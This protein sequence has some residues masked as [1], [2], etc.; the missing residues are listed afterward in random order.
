LTSPQFLAGFVAGNIRELLIKLGLE[1]KEFEGGMKKAQTAIEGLSRTASK[2]SSV[3]TGVFQGIG[4]GIAKGIGNLPASLAALADQGRN[5]NELA[6]SFK[7]L[8]NSSA[9]LD[10]LRSA[11]QGLVSDVELFKSANMAESL[12]ITQQAFGQLAESADA[13]G[14]AVGV[15]TV[16]AL[17]LLTT[18]LGTGNARLL[19]RLGITI[20]AEA[21]EK[22][23]AATLGT[24]ADKLSEAG[25]KEAARGAIMDA[26]TQKTKL[27]GEGTNSLA[28]EL[29]K[30]S[31]SAQNFVASLAGILDKSS[32]LSSFV[33][34]FKL[35]V[36]GIKD[37]I[38]GTKDLAKEL[39]GAQASELVSSLKTVDDLN[40]KIEE[41]F[42]KLGEAKDRLY[43][44][45]DLGK[46]QTIA[47]EV[48]NLD[49][50]L[51]V[52][53]QSFGKFKPVAEEGKKGLIDVGK[54]AGEAAKKFQEFTDKLNADQ[55]KSD[56][57]DIS[58]SFDKIFD[59]ISGSSSGNFN[60]R[61]TSGATQFNSS[62]VALKKNVYESTLA[63]YEKGINDP[64]AVAAATRASEKAASEFQ[65]QFAEV[66]TTT[67]TRFGDELQS[68][69]EAS[70]AF[71]ADA[72]Y[73]VFTGASFDFEDMLKRVGAGLAGGVLGNIFPEFGNIGNLQ[74]LGQ[75][76]GGQLIQGIMGSATSAGGGSFL[77]SLLG[78]GG[79]AAAG[80]IGA[81][82]VATAGGA[83]GLLSGGLVT[84]L[85][86]AAGG[87][88]AA[89][90]IGYSAKQNF[91]GNGNRSKG[92]AALGIDSIFP[93]VGSGLDQLGVLGA[94]G[95]GRGKGGRETDARNSFLDQLGDKRSFQ[96]LRGRIDIQ[97][98]GYNFGNGR[99]AFSDQATGLTRGLAA[100]F[101][102][103][104][105][106]TADLNNMFADAIDDGKSFNETLLEAQNLMAG[107]GI[108]AEDVK[109]S[110][111]DAFLLQVGGL[112]EF[113]ANLQSINQLT[114]ESLP[115]LGDVAGA[116][117]L[118]G[119]E[120]LTWGARIRAIGLGFVEMKELG[121]ENTADISAYLM[122]KFGPSA[123]KLYQ[124][125]SAAGIDSFEDVKNASVDQV[126]FIA[127]TLNGANFGQQFADQAQIAADATAIHTQRMVDDFNR[128]GQAASNAA[129]QVNAASITGGAVATVNNAGK[130]DPNPT[131]AK[132]VN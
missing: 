94:L 42:N 123:V 37:E 49:Y 60:D 44:E 98:S 85:G 75:K 64:A 108:N 51:D 57:D 70:S 5:F 93:G 11:T 35:G 22:K 104:E 38:L 84:S 77:G 78:T 55:L 23:L 82:G 113:N 128:V 121:I 31:I 36:I 2:E 50:Q 21:A 129:S 125:L 30:A 58:K 76:I 26:V 48:D 90:L 69:I 34:N 86:I 81:G 79:G 54:G 83:G 47:A 74:E 96:G 29:Q 88:A 73:N 19:K 1:S 117:Q 65:D 109:N 13:L 80:G 3:I 115:G 4:Q 28:D 72:F 52:L 126:N 131:N 15:D 101:G 91:S 25:K 92:S 124:D 106:F 95:F 120:S 59:S 16:Q 43:A 40:N 41:T 17:E 9:D 32:T 110:I 89:A 61:L 67:A 63:G 102:G 27:L 10:R 111:K 7:A 45:T 132:Y 118:A 116:L 127:N 114:A 107:L 87:A 6:G 12:G 53:S 119:D 8:G 112:E 122:D 20:D 97:E 33:S 18:S 14:D 46:K 100:S 130:I 71:F 68:Q 56:A 99:T 105:K 24:T 39:G 62:L 66:T 103:N